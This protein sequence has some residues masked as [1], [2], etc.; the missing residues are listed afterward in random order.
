MRGHRLTKN[1]A[2][3]A[4]LALLV[5]ACGIRAEHFGDAGAQLP[6]PSERSYTVS[7]D[8]EATDAVRAALRDAGF[9]ER[10]DAPLRIDVGFAIRPRRLAVVTADADG[11]QDVLSPSADKVLSLCSRQAYVLTLAFVERDSG[12]IAS[13][14]GATLTRCD[15]T[16]DEIMPRLARAALPFG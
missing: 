4:V 1:G 12:R 10:A 3:A 2:G 13:R 5:G 14:S 9:A 6:L 16:P 11:A 7:G 15:G 8:G